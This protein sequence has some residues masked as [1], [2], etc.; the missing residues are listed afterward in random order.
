MCE[1][2]CTCVCVYAYMR[3]HVFVCVLICGCVCC[4]C[5]SVC[6]FA[7]MLLH[8]CVCVCVCVCVFVCVCVCTFVCVGAYVCGCNCKYGNA[9]LCNSILYQGGIYLVKMRYIITK[10]VFIAIITGSCPHCQP[11]I[12]LIIDT[13]DSIKNDTLRN[14]FQTLGQF[15]G[16]LDVGTADNQVQVAVVTFGKEA[17]NPIGFNSHTNN[18]SLAAA[19]R[20]LSRVA[21]SHGTKTS[22]ALDKCRGLFRNDSCNNTIV[23]VTDGTSGEGDILTAAIERVKAENITVIAIGVAT[24]IHKTEKTANIN[25]QLLKIALDKSENTF[26]STFDELSGYLTGKIVSDL[27]ICSKCPNTSACFH[28]HYMCLNVHYY[29]Y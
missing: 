4:E 3:V 12:C 9:S 17:E 26:I 21:K 2:A 25:Q 11:D 15:A 6:M 14:L 16:Q 13:S 28:E 19:I 29:Y 8:V 23:L 20:G 5:I 22:K 7:C 18:A 27:Q 24:K 1:H 10:T